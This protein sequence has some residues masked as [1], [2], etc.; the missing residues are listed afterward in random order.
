[1]SKIITSENV[2]V[3]YGKQR[4]INNINLDFNVHNITALIGPSGSG[5]ST[6]LRCL[7]RMN[8]LINNVTV[9]GSIKLN[10][11]DIFSPQMDI[12]NLRKTVGMV[13]QQPIPFPFSIYENVAYGLRLNGI[14]EKKI[15]DVRIEKA[16]RQ[17]ALWEEVKDSLHDNGFS[18][19]GGQQQRLCIARVLAV[20]PEV[21]LLDEPTSALDPISSAQIEDTLVSLKNEFTF[22]IVTHNMQQASRISDWTAF[23][24]D[25]KLEE[26]SAT[27]KLFLNPDKEKTSDYLNGKFG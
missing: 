14:K 2:S 17:S 24:L 12:V 13:F 27:Q 11:K 23:F 21:V 25:G 26:Y 16:L 4:A 7:N 15:L 8:D 1:M 5:K 6:Y 22:I 20:E 10:G 9:S 3:Y 19:S 18:L